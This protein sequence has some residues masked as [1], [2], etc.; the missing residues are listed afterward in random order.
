SFRPPKRLAALEEVDPGFKR[1]LAKVTGISRTSLYD[2]S[3]V[4]TRKDK[5]L[6]LE[7]RAAHDRHPLYGDFAAD[8]SKTA[9]TGCFDSH[10]HAQPD[11]A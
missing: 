4:Q 6:I 3:V 8:S 10:Q 7:L 1:Q 5:Q 2:R 11:R 9:S